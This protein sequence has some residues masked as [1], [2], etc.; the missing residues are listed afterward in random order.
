M[1][2]ALVVVSDLVVVITLVVVIYYTQLLERFHSA[3]MPQWLRWLRRSTLFTMIASVLGV[4]YRII[5]GDAV[6]QWPGTIFA[7]AINVYFC[8]QIYVIRKD[9]SAVV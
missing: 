5:D 9:H 6:L 3:D 2:T 4:A 8:I 1:E 7:V